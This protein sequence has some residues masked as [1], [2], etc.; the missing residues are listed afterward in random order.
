MI[1]L[2]NKYLSLNF[3]ITDEY[4]KPQTKVLYHG[5]TKVDHGIAKVD[6]GTT[7]HCC[8]NQKHWLGH[9]KV[10]SVCYPETVE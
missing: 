5:I 9:Y 6:N 3:D 7:V 8:T 10:Q 2:T 1:Q 4:S